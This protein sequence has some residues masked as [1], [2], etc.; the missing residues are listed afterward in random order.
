M[1]TSPYKAYCRRTEDF[2]EMQIPLLEQHLLSTTDHE[3]S[4]TV[5]TAAVS[6]MPRKLLAIY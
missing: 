3:A 1:T 2:E 5:G 4:F 6:E